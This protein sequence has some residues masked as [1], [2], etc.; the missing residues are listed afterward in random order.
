MIGS[1]CSA[2]AIV[3]VAVIVGP[4]RGTA[5]QSMRVTGP[6]GVTIDGIFDEAVWQMVAPITGLRQQEP[7][8]GAPATEATEIRV[9]HDSTTLYIGIMA[10]DREPDRVIGRILQRDRV[11]QWD[12]NGLQFAGDDAVAILIDAFHD[13]RNAIVFATNSN[14]AEFDAQVGDEGRDVNVNWRGVWSV[15]AQRHGDG[16]SAEFAIPLS[17]LRAA[18]RGN[19]AWGF[20]VYRVIRRRNE[21][22][23]WRSWGRDG[24]GFLRVSRAGDLHGVA[25]AASGGAGIDIKPYALTR[26]TEQG[27]GASAPGRSGELDVGLDV[28]YEVHPGLVI[29]GTIN[30]DFAQVEVDDAQVNL[31][32]FDLF[33]PEKRE[34]FLENSGIFEFGVRGDGEPPPFLMFFSRRIGVSDAGVVPLLGGV[35]MSGRLGR[36]TLGV[37][38]AITAEA[39]G[40]PRQAHTVARLK[41]DVGASGYVGGMVTRV[42]STDAT[43]VAG[44][45]DWSLWPTKTLNIQGFAART[46]NPSGGDATAYR[47]GV[48]YQTDRVGFSGQHLYIGP[49]TQADLGFITRT[50]IRRNHGLLRLTGRPSALGLRTVNLMIVGEYITR[51]DG[52]PQ[53]WTTGPAL[54][55]NWNSGETVTPYLKTGRTRLDEGFQLG[56][57]VP[58]LPGDYRT[59]D[60]GLMASTST[61]R[62][63]SAT[64]HLMRQQVYDGRIVTAILSA[65]V[66]AGA[67]A[68]IDAAFTRGDVALPEGSFTTNLVSLRTVYAFSTRLSASARVQYNELDGRVTTSA[69]LEYQYRPGSDLFVVL[70]DG[71]ATSGVTALPEQRAAVVKFTWL[72]RL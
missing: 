14:G 41:R 9:F 63:I 59:L 35:R 29:D 46:S 47:L 19:G 51:T 70:E 27:A 58:V 67:R 37:L 24:E 57:L 1:R 60:L 22:V 33:L 16:W 56:G 65:R 3:V 10:F 11:M 34:F 21:H 44:G 55:L 36:Q 8:E 64:A 38:H 30:A 49:N 68:F 42:G 13:H 15:A 25:G 52:E 31:T 2:A 5:Q 39:H 28:K 26:A 69:R 43:N 18:G 54:G 66:A 20:N 6:V 50:D 61:A 7:D 53:D 23:L 72:A 4:Q 62:W 32:R 17:T 40:Q 45:L 71:R 48:D 12:G